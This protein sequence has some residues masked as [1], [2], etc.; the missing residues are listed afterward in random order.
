MTVFR[1][2]EQFTTKDLK[3]AN[4]GETNKCDS[5]PSYGKAFSCSEHNKQRPAGEFKINMEGTGFYV[6]DEVM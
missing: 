4:A 3:G 6:P 2:D 1:E 5:Y